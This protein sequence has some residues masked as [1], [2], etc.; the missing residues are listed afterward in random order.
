MMSSKRTANWLDAML[1]VAKCSASLSPLPL[2]EAD[3]PRPPPGRAR[4]AAAA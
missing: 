2:N 1:K 4:R 3:G